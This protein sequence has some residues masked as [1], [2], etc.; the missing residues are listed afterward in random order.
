MTKVHPSVTALW[1]AFLKTHPD[2]PKELPPVFYFCDNQR[3]ADHCA[4]LV[5][6][7]R[8]RATAASL[9]ELELSGDPIPKPGDRAIVTMWDG[10]AVALIRTRSVELTRFDEV[11]A[12]F[13]AEEGE[14]DLTLAWWRE[15]HE[16]YYR[17]V[18][19]GTRFEFSEALMIACERFE[20]VLKA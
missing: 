5:R 3:D 13:A 1:Q 2:V 6:E 7:G 15:A 9:A 12:E 19:S 8:K 16:A 10:E 4:E 17:R 11:D 20:T 14:G 18:L